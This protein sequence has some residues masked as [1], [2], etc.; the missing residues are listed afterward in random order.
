MTD[1][2]PSQ[3]TSTSRATKA[4]K[5]RLVPTNWASGLVVLFVILIVTGVA[6]AL[7]P[8]VSTALDG[9]QSLTDALPN[10]LF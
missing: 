10:L 2:W 1:L 5:A 7:W 3:R 6:T 8:L 4:P 9:V